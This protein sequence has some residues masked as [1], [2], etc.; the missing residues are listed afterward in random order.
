ML[1]G[2]S[3][4]TFVLV[5]ALPGDPMRAFLGSKAS[6]ET[7]ERIR[8]QYG[9]D[10]PVLVQYHFLKNLTPMFDL[11]LQLLARHVGVLKPVVG[12]DLL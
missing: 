5:H 10:R 1:F 8:A 2:I 11:M 4:V 3:L 9:L 7:V 6:E 12:N